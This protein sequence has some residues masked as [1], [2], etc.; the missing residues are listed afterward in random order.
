LTS[1]LQAW[2]RLSISQGCSAAALEQ[3]MRASG[4]ARDF[5]EGAVAAALEVLA[6]PVA[7]ADQTVR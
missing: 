3:S 1:E 4:Y 6:A 5:A 2:L 7:K